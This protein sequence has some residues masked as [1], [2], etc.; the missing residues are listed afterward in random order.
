[1]LAS[2]A[3]LGSGTGSFLVS[4]GGLV[5]LQNKDS[6]GIGNL[7]FFEIADIFKTKMLEI[8]GHTA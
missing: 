5:Y 3:C 2:K 7:A 1:M 6:C 8:S 4:I